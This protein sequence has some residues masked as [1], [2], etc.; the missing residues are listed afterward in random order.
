MEFNGQSHLQTAASSSAF[1]ALVLERRASEGK[2]ANR[3]LSAVPHRQP[4]AH[5]LLKAARWP[6]V[7]L[8]PACRSDGVASEGQLRPV[9]HLCNLRLSS[10]S[11][12]VQNCQNV[13]IVIKILM[14]KNQQLVIIPEEQVLTAFISGALHGKPEKS[15]NHHAVCM[16][17][18]VIILKYDQNQKRSGS[19]L[20]AGGENPAYGGWEL[21]SPAHRSHFQMFSLLVSSP[22]S[23]YL[24]RQERESPAGTKTPHSTLFELWHIVLYPQSSLGDFCKMPNH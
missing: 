12:C 3:S 7:G 24:A 20:R 2:A 18:A 5:L 17:S 6:G 19:F 8:K 10:P 15:L 11:A 14:S 21:G 16:F 13:Q 1:G 9:N 22:L 23:V 4:S